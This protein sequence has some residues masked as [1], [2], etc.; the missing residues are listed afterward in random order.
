[1][2][3]FVREPNFPRPKFADLYLSL[4]RLWG[5]MNAGIGLGREDGHVLLELSSALLQLNHGLN[6]V[7]LIIEEW[8]SAR[9]VP[10]QLPF[11]L[12]AIELL[13]PR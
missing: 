13:F 7:K 12:D 8:W 11:A 6:E 3:D 4:L 9:P 1:M 10:S 5:D 2:D